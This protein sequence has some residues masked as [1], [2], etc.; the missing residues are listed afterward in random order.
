MSQ[1]VKRAKTFE[2]QR[3]VKRLKAHKAKSEDASD[4]KEGREALEK[5]LEATKAID[6][7]AV[8]VPALLTKLGKA[9]ML[10]RGGDAA[11]GEEDK[12]PLVA[13]LGPS[14]VLIKE[15]QKRREQSKDGSGPSAASAHETVRS[16]LV[17][18]KVVSDEVSKGVEE[19]GVLLGLTSQKRSIEKVRKGPSSVSKEPRSLA[20]EVAKPEKVRIEPRDTAESESSD[21]NEE[22]ANS[23]G[24]AD[25]K[26]IEQTKERKRKRSPP[27]ASSEEP[28]PMDEEDGLEEN[29]EEDGDSMSGSEDEEEATFLPSLATGF[30]GGR[31]LNLGRRSDDEW[32]DGDAELESID[33]DAEDRGLDGKVRAGANRKNRMGQRARKA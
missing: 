26:K 2:T 12:F 13:I 11:E 4:S 18:S 27:V 17:S 3:T 29:E 8:A 32:S 25:G 7:Q 21:E 19:I 22:D 9:R 1:S 23:L 20:K 14:H 5:E 30:V 16:R 15:A 10:P 24:E 28:S 31:G 6:T 33:S